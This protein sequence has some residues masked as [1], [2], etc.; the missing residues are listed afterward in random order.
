M[1][2]S[3]FDTQEIHDF[4]L[5]YNFIKNLGKDEKLIAE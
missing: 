4:D 1:E 2:I 5:T 3:R